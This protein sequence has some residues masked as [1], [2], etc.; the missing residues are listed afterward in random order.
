[1]SP[2]AVGGGQVSDAACLERAMTALGN[3]FIPAAIGWG[4]GPM[5]SSA[6]VRFSYYLDKTHG[7]NGSVTVAQQQDS[8]LSMEEEQVAWQFAEGR[9]AQLRGG[10]VV[11]GLE[12]SE[13]EAALLKV[14]RAQLN[15]RH[16]M[17]LIVIHHALCRKP[18]LQALPDL[19]Q[20]AA[21]GVEDLSTRRA[22]GT[23]AADDHHRTQQQ[24]GQD[25][26][27]MLFLQLHAAQLDVP[28]RHTVVDSLGCTQ[29][30]LVVGSRR[31]AILHQRVTALICIK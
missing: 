4:S 31:T 18:M 17:R 1:M 13:N 15:C 20:R 2:V 21:A 27:D 19:E 8:S 12:L 3:G 24:H 10:N 29:L 7:T 28:H 22:S 5:F 16:C 6:L 11:N 30:L 26:K 14:R 23:G 9:E 25:N